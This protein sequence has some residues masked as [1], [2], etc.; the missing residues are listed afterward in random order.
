MKY[1]SCLILLLGSLA[2]AGGSGGTMHPFE[3]NNNTQIVYSM[4]EQNG[5][6]KFSSAQL[7][8]GQW[9]VQTHALPASD[10]AQD[11]AVSTALKA[12]QS[13]NQWAQIK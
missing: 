9:Q 2:F 1:F 12:S 8:D 11:E 5:L 4:G 3:I 6:V 10:V 13:L 7:V